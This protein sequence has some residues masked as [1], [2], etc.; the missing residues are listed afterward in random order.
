MVAIA[1]LLI[2]LLCSLAGRLLLARAA[3]AISASWGVAVLL[4]PFAPAFFRINYPGQARISRALG[5]VALP[6][7]LG[8]FM[9]GG[10]GC[11]K[12]PPG[13]GGTTK[14][15]AA[16]TASPS[17]STSPTATP[18]PTP[19]IQERLAANQR[20]FKRLD[21]WFADLSYRRRDLTKLDQQGI[22]AF[23][24]EAQHYEEALKK[25]RDDQAAIARMKK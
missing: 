24:E 1:L 5:L 10:T 7:L 9:L 3:F 19:T 6:C 13:P 20:E 17:P 2:G 11:L 12:A 18:A 8:F 21:Q 4:V 16:K 22:H 23:N 15:Q 14:K 25:A